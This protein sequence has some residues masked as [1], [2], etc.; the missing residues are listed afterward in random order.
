MVTDI[1]AKLS[2][3]VDMIM[4]N[5]PFSLITAYQIL[6]IDGVGRGIAV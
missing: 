5:I 1:G 2:V 3:P 4:P 6:A